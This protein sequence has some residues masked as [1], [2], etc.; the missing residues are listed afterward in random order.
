[1]L[2]GYNFFH[3]AGLLH[4]Q[5][6]SRDHENVRAGPISLHT[7]LEGPREHVNARWM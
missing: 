6:K 7:T 3:I 1:M 5:A 2:C 4:T